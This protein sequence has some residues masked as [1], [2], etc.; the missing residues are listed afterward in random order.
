MTTAITLIDLANLSIGTPEVGAINF[1]A[2]HTLLHAIIKHLNI[3]DMKTEML[4]EEMGPNKPLG[5][6]S[7]A[8]NGKGAQ[9]YLPMEQKMQEIERQ[10]EALNSLPSGSDLLERTKA[11]GQLALSTPLGDMWQMMQMKKRIETN[12]DGISKVMELLEDLLHEINILKDTRK[13]VEN[14]LQK[15]TD[16]VALGG[17]KDLQERLSQLEEQNTATQD[18]EILQKQMDLIQQR[19]SHLEQKL[20][21]FPSSEQLHN[22]VGWEVLHETLV[23]PQVTKD[24]QSLLTTIS[25]QKYSRSEPKHNGSC[26]SLQQITQEVS[27]QP[28]LQ[29]GN[30]NDVHQ[31]LQKTSTRE[32]QLGVQKSPQQPPSDSIPTCQNDPNGLSAAAA[33]L[34][35]TNLPGFSGVSPISQDSA[36]QENPNEPTSMDQPT[37]DHKSNAQSDCNPYLYVKKSLPTTPPSSSDSSSASKPYADTVEALRKIGALTEQ[38]AVLLEKIRALERDKADQADMM[39]LRVKIDGCGF[40]ET[41]DRLSDVQEKLKLLQKNMQDLKMEREKNLELIGHIQNTMLHLQEECDK[42]TMTTSNLIDNRQQEQR[43]IKKILCQSME[44]LDEEKAD[45]EHTELQTEVKADEQPPDAKVSRSQFDAT[46]EQLNSMIQ[47]LLSRVNMQEQ[48]W[49]RMLEKINLE[50]QNKLDRIELDPFKKKLE[51]RWKVIIRQL[52]ERQPKCESDEAAGIRKQL[53]AQFHCISCDRPVEMMV[54][55][56]QVITIPNTP[57]FPAHRS[58]RPYTVY[59]LEQIRQ[60]NRNE[61][62]PELNDFMSGTRS[63]GGSHTLTLPHRRYVKLQS[64]IRTSMDEDILASIP[65]QTEVDILGFDGHIYK[66]RM[67]TC[68]P[69]ISSKDGVPTVLKARK[70]YQGSQKYLPAFDGYTPPSRPQSAKSTGRSQTALFQ[71]S[72][73][74]TSSASPSLQQPNALTGTHHTL[75]INM[76]V[77]LNQQQA[78]GSVM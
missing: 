50:M 30:Q 54:P 49:Q 36:T 35:S 21:T 38:H 76:D 65:K 59:E 68:F 64:I 69:A 11:E 10:L 61:R 53:I 78:D 70:Y 7:K 52:Q 75:T 46:A 43:H 23:R 55:G 74:L 33:K 4:G 32:Y 9:V 60:Q 25:K 5:M 17:L 40:I 14:Q 73:D 31:G 51:E 19:V 20:A 57:A 72:K 47:D 56:P 6:C 37:Q 1:N 16:E 41:T 3:Q 13:D 22:M 58:N 71:V 66:G 18:M 44:N 34:E 2:L 8:E 67:D 28:V 39:M 12:E 77:N 27:S 63:C 45:K 15:M 24:A 26:D 62:F 48:D 29:Q 42:L